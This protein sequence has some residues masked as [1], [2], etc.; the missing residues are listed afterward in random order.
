M[1]SRVSLGSGECS[2]VSSGSGEGSRVSSGLGEGKCGLSG[3]CSNAVFREG[4][5]EP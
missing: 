1:G 3:E 2:R 5:G 4:E